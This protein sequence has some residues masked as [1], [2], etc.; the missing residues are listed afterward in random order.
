MKQGPELVQGLLVE[1]GWA[2]LLVVAGR[3][4]YRLG[5]RHYSAYGG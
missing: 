5:L 3:R 1:L 4:L 2:V